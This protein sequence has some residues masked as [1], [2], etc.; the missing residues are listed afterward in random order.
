MPGF[1]VVGFGALNVDKLFK[2]NRI[3]EAEE[4]SFVQSHSESCGGSA[5]NTIVGLARLGCKVGFIGKIAGDREG[6]LLLEDFEREGVDTA[7]LIRV[8]QGDSGQ[9]IGFVDN[10]GNRALYIESG[11]NDTIT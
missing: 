8:G 6:A 1:D 5:A 11:I 4:E 2:V 10:E 7:G 3:A 9:V